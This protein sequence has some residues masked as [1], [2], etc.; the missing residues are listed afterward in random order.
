MTTR[1]EVWHSALLTLYSDGEF[2][3][4][5]LPFE[6]SQAH[7]VR[8]VLRDMEEKGWLSREHENSG[9]WMRGPLADALLASQEFRDVDAVLDQLEE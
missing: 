8:R 5:D 7:T 2:R 4:A 9:I 1:D 3:I 6:E